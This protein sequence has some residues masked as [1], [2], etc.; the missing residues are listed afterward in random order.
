[1][2]ELVNSRFERKV[3]GF[4]M[5]EG[6]PETILLHQ[7][8]ISNAN[9]ERRVARARNAYPVE[10]MIRV[11]LSNYPSMAVFA[12]FAG[13][14]TAR[15]QKGSA[16]QGNGSSLGSMYLCHKALGVSGSWRGT[17]RRGS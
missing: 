1:M 5:M 2:S 17:Q 3:P 13:V 9:H 12:D 15:K 8:P 11:I 4:R 6:P 16:Q 7:S 10:R 14:D